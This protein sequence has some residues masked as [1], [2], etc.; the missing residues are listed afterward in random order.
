MQS[1]TQKIS[2]R[3]IVLGGI[4][5]AMIA[6]DFAA[7]QRTMVGPFAGAAR[8]ESMPMLSRPNRFGHVYGNTMRRRY[9]RQQAGSYSQPVRQ[10]ASYSAPSYNS[11]PTYN[12]TPTYNSAPSYN[13]AYPT[14]YTP[15]ATEQT[16]VPV[17][18]SSATVP[19]D[20]V[21]VVN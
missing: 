14:Y 18:W 17:T 2:K 5:L 8:Y 1:T 10:T 12:S 4:V 9:D 15:A 21:S 7:A 6:C 16:V 20:P 11:A 19:V 13:S 3:I